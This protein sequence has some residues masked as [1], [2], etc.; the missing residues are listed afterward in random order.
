[1]VLQQALPQDFPH[2]GDAPGA[3]PGKFA[4][5][6]AFSRISLALKRPSPLRFSA[7]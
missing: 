2:P 6:G 1:M 4:G 3:Q 7:I 5:H